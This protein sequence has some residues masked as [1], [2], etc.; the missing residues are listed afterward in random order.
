MLIINIQYCSKVQLDSF[1]GILHSKMKILSSIINPQVVANLFLSYFL[2]LN[3]KEDI[4]K[5]D[6]NFGTIDFHSLVFFL[7]WKSMVPNNCLVSIVLQNIFLR[8]QQKKETQKQVCN[9]LRVNNWR[10]DF[11]FWVEYPF[12]GITVLL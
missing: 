10:Q 9:N 4:L 1:K 11:H 2:L 8:V 12:K 6:W 7:L 5:N 3:T